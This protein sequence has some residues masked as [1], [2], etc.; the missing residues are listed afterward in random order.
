MFAKINSLLNQ[1]N[2][3]LLIFRLVLVV[4]IRN[5]EA[6]PASVWMQYMISVSIMFEVLTF[7]QRCTTLLSDKAKMDQGQ[8]LDVPRH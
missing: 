6:V 3:N 2:L 5:L 4:I 8:S 7:E 1:G